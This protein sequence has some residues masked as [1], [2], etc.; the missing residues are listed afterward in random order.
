MTVIKGERKL[1]TYSLC[2]NTLPE[3]FLFYRKF[4]FRGVSFIYSIITIF[5]KFVYYLSR[6]GRALKLTLL[7]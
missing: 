3:N 1:L 7:E 2:D 5:S 4:V 6:L